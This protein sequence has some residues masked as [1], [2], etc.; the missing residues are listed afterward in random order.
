MNSRL[1]NL[2]VEPGGNRNKVE[3][4]VAILLFCLAERRLQDFRECS[5]IQHD[6]STGA[7]RRLDTRRQSREMALCNPEA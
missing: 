1:A 4:K 5:R 3:A 7:N 6:T 2:V